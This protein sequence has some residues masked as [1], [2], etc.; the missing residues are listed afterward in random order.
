MIFIITTQTPFLSLN[1]NPCHNRP[2]VGIVALVLE[3][4]FVLLPDDVSYRHDGTLN[5]NVV[6]WAKVEFTSIKTKASSTPLLVISEPS[7]KTSVCGFS[8]FVC[9]CLL[10]CFCFFFFFFMA[11]C[12]PAPESVTACLPGPKNFLWAHLSGYNQS[13]TIVSTSGHRE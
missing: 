6:T 13:I 4:E 3:H 10:K 1:P 7:A 8:D 2:I 12:H 5:K 11:A 9:L